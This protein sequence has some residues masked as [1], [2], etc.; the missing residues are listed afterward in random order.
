MQDNKPFNKRRKGKKNN[1]SKKNNK[2][3][4]KQEQRVD[5]ELLQ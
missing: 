3:I 5:K 4:P 2:F 1:S